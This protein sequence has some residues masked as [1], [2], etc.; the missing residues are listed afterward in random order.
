MKKYF[1]IL[2]CL[3]LLTGCDDDND[4]IYKIDLSHDPYDIC[5]KKIY[6][7]NDADGNELRMERIIENIEENCEVYKIEEAKKE[8]KNILYDE[9][10]TKEEIRRDLN[11]IYNMLD[12]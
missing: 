7:S 11:D 1:I 5:G 2:L 3:F 6:I 12:K 4:S 10:R 8:I 9:D